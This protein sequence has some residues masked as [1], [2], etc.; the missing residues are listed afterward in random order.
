METEAHQKPAETPDPIADAGAEARREV[1][2]QL[3]GPVAQRFAELLPGLGAKGDPYKTA[4]ATPDILF[5]CAQVF[6]AKREAFAEFLVDAEGN[7]VTDDETRLACGRSV[8]EIVGMVV[9]TGMRSFAEGHFGDPINPARA[10][11]LAA[12]KRAEPMG[13]RFWKLLDISK[14]SA[15]F[16]KNYGTEA[17][18]PKGTTLSGRFYAAIKD[19][20]DFEWQIKFF[21]LYVE[22]PS[23]VFDKLGV[24]ITRMDT[25]ERL[26]R[27]AKLAIADINKAEQ[28]LGDPALTR[29]M[30]DNNVLA[31]K[32]VSDLG[33]EFHDIHNVLLESSMG[34]K[35]KWDALAN[36]DT[37]KKLAT[38]KRVTK[39]DI[40]ALADYL[41]ILNETA[42]D[43]MLDL[44]LTR[45]Q[46]QMFLKAAEENL[47]PGLF[48]ALFGPQQTEMPD[49]KAEQERIRKYLSFSE[50]ALRNL[51]K[52]VKQLEEQA[53]KSG[54]GGVEE[55]LATVCRARRPDLEKEM[56]KFMPPRGA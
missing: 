29:E 18:P 56:K 49:N 23:H 34:T 19:H 48:V 33:D 27:L 30:I 3:K 12:T 47:G 42:L 21:P 28:V 7:P 26:M 40:A 1:T 55:N 8:T 5:S 17:P 35:K 14:L 46:M 11:K 16:R 32:T 37:M 53:R 50:T 43:C 15:L 41:D 13:S 9:R 6:R 45:D 22:I 24:G 10:A 25:E 52:A 36:R 54:G 4:M 44:H 51:V 2:R 38:D 20:L 31:S 39:Q